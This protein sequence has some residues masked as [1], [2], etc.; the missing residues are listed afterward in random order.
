MEK[1]I[2]LIIVM[3]L[4]LVSSTCKPKDSNKIKEPKMVSVHG[5]TFIMGC[6]KEQENDCVYDE[7][8]AHQV[9]LSSFKIAKY[10]VTQDL[11][12]QIMGYNPSYF[13][14]ANLP[15]EGVNWGDVQEFIR[16]LNEATGKKYRLPTEAEW[17]FAAR[18]GNKSKGY[19]YSGSNEIDAVAW[20]DNNSHGEVHPVGAKAPNELGIYD[21]SGNVWEWCSDWFGAY[22]D[23]SLTN[24]QGPSTGTARILRGGCW[25]TI[26]QMSRVSYR[27]YFAPENRHAFFGF[28]VVE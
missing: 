28:R 4:V 11:W 17:E 1:T 20:Y 10:P 24:P 3:L 27:D 18:G 9:T 23:E 25:Y 13:K 14:G 12:E 7:I 16:K 15:V 22:S 8:P 2:T 19:L 21:M 26:P 5:G 6:S